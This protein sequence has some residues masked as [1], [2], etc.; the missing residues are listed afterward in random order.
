VT[1]NQH[2]VY[3]LPIDTSNAVSMKMYADWL[4]KAQLDYALTLYLRDLSKL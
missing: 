4:R 1:K 2:G 3:D